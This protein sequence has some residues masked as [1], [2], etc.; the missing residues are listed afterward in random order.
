M[1]MY[2]K[3]MALFLILMM[4]VSGLVVDFNKESEV[5]AAEGS[6]VTADTPEIEMFR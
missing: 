3:T 2:K 5:Q 6:G 1:K 4:I